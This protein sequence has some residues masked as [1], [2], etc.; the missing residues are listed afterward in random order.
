MDQNKGLIIAVVGL[1]LFAGGGLAAAHWGLISGNNSART[2]YRVVHS[3]PVVLVDPAPVA[4][5]ANSTPVPAASPAQP[6][7]VAPPP[8]SAPVSSAPPAHPH[9]AAPP[10]QP[11]A[12][13]GH[14]ETASTASAM[15]YVRTNLP[16][17]STA[18]Q[19]LMAVILLGSAPSEWSTAVQSM[20]DYF[21]QSALDEVLL[22]LPPT[23]QQ[24]MESQQLSS[25]LVQPVMQT[26]VA[27][28]VANIQ[29]SYVAAQLEAGVQ[30][31]GQMWACALGGG[32]TV[33][34]LN[35]SYAGCIN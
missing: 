1:G 26:M 3:A 8:A 32:G 19:S 35:G 10:S 9:P 27:I 20:S 2:A 25:D 13:S 11:S 23:V 31:S 28:I 21:G 14:R 16:G 29:N 18:E 4:S 24:E 34:W 17:L 6:P 30:S 22:N 15:Q 5:S 12:P 7:Q 33:T